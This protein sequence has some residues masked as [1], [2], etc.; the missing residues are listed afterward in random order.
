MGEKEIRSGT[1]VTLSYFSAQ[2]S[3]SVGFSAEKEESADMEVSTNYMRWNNICLSLWN[4]YCNGRDRA[5][6]NGI[7]R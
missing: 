2:K 5:F 6:L 7:Q 1:R 3:V 4:L